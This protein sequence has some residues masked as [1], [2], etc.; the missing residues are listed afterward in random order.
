[1]TAALETFATIGEPQGR[2]V[3]LGGMLELGPHAAEHHK[4]IG[5]WV[6]RIGV[7]RL[8]TVGD[9]ARWIA[10]GAQ[11]AG[12]ASGRIRHALTP[13]DVDPVLP[14]SLRPGAAILFKGS[15]RCGLD[16]AVRLVRGRLEAD[17]RDG[18]GGIKRPV[19]RSGSGSGRHRS[20]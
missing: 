12:L 11:Q 13:H 9:E 4:A 2:I 20:A 7:E 1:V 18:S 8:V 14:P 6:A 19:S 3:V 10:E 17:R 15:R 16:E 5:R